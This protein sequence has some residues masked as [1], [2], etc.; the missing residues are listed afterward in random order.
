MFD[1]KIIAPV[2]FNK[3]ALPTSF[4]QHCQTYVTAK[5]LS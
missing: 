1:D 2:K 3:T 5:S 4:Q